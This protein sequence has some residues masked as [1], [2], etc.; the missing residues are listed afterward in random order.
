MQNKFILPVIFVL[1]AFNSFSYSDPKVLTSSAII[2]NY[3]NAEKAYQQKDYKEAAEY[4]G[5]VKLESSSFS[6]S[7]HFK[8]AYSLYQTGEHNF[9]LGNLEAIGVKSPEYLPHYIE[10]FRIKNLWELSKTTAAGRAEKFISAYPKTSLA[11]SLLLSLANYYYTT[12]NFSKARMYY[13][14]HQQWNVD[15]TRN[16]FTS[17]RSAMCLY[18]LNRR[19][20]AR[21]E[22]IQVLS[23]FEKAEETLDFV[24]WLAV[25]EKD[26]Y[27]THFFKVV[28]VYF[29]NKEYTSLNDILEGYIKTS[30]DESLKEKARFNLIKLY[31]EKGHNNPALYGFQ[32]MLKGLKNKTLEPY[33]RLYIARIY[34]RK[35]QRQEAIEAYIDYAHRY[36]RRRIAPEAVWKSA[37]IAEELNDLIQAN[38]LY[39]EVRTRWAG[40]SLAREAYFREGFTQYRMD[41]VGAALKIFNEIRYKRWPDIDKHRAQYWASLCMDQ[42][43]MYKEAS[44]ARIELAKNFWDD[45]YTMKSYLMHKNEIDFNKGI[46]QNFRENENQLKSSLKDLTGLL[47]NFEMAFEVKNILGESYA[48]GELEDIQLKA[49]SLDEWVGLAEIYKKLNAYGKAFRAYDYINNK[50][51]SDI[52]FNQKSFILKERFPFYYDILVEKHGGENQ[53]E[54]ELILALMKQESVFDFKAHSWANAFG[55]MQLIP[56]T[57]Q[58]MAIQKNET[59]TN[60]RQLFD[61]EFNIMLGTQYLKELSDRYNGQK[62]WMLAAYNAGPHRVNRWKQLPGSGQVEVFIENVEF[63]E[64]R[65]YVRKVMKNYWAYKLLQSN[66]QIGPEELLLGSLSH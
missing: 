8:Y 29:G 4:F 36:P 2:D 35:D 66:F 63:S 62:E 51:F 54:P 25:N 6:S 50:Y 22:F 11:D 28:D 31:F 23:N 19:N 65:T 17:I 12:N 53:I 3:E 15:K 39:H 5:L 37:W 26:L 60:S 58:A 14:L 52:P 46:V 18:K 33:I 34:L 61:P 24:I 30:D 40:N 57:A 1:A 27:K 20:E 10:F 48:F 59:Y 21:H 55:L 44:M 13:M 45:Y 41:K 49:N 42:L 7:S 38:K 56:S 16:A 32:N 9:S 64:T 47:N 43:G